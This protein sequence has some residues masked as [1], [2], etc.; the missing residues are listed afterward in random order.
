MRILERMRQ[1]L[2][3]PPSFVQRSPTPATSSTLSEALATMRDSA[4]TPGA[5]DLVRRLSELERT[6]RNSL[7]GGS[8][9]LVHPEL[10]QLQNVVKESFDI[11]TSNG[12]TVFRTTLSNVSL[13]PLVWFKKKH[14]VQIDK[15]SA[16]QRIPETLVREAY[17][18]RLRPLFSDITVQFVDPYQSKP[19]S[20]SPNRGRVL[21]HVHA[22]VQMVV[23]YL[24]STTAPLRPRTIGTSKDACYLCH[25]FIT[26]Q[27]LFRTS[28]TH[29]RLYD[30]WTIPDLADYSPGQVRVLRA[31]IR[32]MNDEFL[33]LASGKRMPRCYPLTSRHNLRIYP[34]F[35]PKSSILSAL[36]ELTSLQVTEEVT[37][38]Q[39]GH[40][41]A[42]STSESTCTPGRT[43]DSLSGEADIP[44]PCPQ[45]A[46]E[47]VR[48]AHPN[49]SPEPSPVQIRRNQPHFATFP[50]LEIMV[51]IGAP[52]TGKIYWRK[53]GRVDKIAEEE[54]VVRIGSLEAGEEMH[55]QRRDT[56]DSVVLHLERLEGDV[57][58][59]ILQWQ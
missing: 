19:S 37:Q 21:C 17:R 29:G 44:T 13:D 24:L 41:D 55:F 30:Q 59:V 12:R 47:T 20:I 46:P 42:S 28:A 10:P 18:R 7:S 51:E 1:C 54:N 3:L 40:P 31:T 25:S 16:Y 27:A 33:R 53:A 58:S 39:D 43:R 26:K 50:G 34:E 48:P 9:P 2:G 8:S 15:L 4:T 5:R 22:E 6:I 11:T 23:H 49:P 45:S 57:C 14:I 52:R 35:S 36:P 32:M 56:E 38:D